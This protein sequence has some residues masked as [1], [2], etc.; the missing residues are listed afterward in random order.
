MDFCFKIARGL[1][2]SGGYVDVFEAEEGWL[3]FTRSDFFKE[4]ARL[5]GRPL[6]EAVKRVLYDPNLLFIAAS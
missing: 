4:S 6:N 1:G 5:L 2:L 3:A